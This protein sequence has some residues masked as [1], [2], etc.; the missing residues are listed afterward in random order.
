M[1]KQDPKHMIYAATARCD[2]GAG[3]AYGTEDRLPGPF[4]A[5]SAWDCSAILL[6]EAVPAGQPGAVGHTQPL[7][8]SMYEI[9]SENQ[10]S[11]N[12]HSTR[13]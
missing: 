6:Q 10:P 13:P 7:P 12:G 9:K 2:C 4:R 11:A 3:L 5:P 8:F 1:K